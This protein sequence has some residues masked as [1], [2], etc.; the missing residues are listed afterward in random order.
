V[1]GSS[2]AGLAIG[3]VEV[4]SEVVPT[5]TV[6]AERKRI[7]ERI[8]ALEAEMRGLDRGILD[9]NFQ[10]ELLSALARSAIEPR[11]G[12][13]QAIITAAELAQIL[14][15]AAGRLEGV[16]RKVAEAEAR[17]R[18]IGKEIEELRR[19]EQLLS[20]QQSYRSVVTVALEAERAGEAR[21]AVRYTVGEAGWSPLYD[22]RLDTGTKDRAPSLSL[23]SRAEV[24]Q[25][26]PESWDGVTLTL[27]TARVTG[28][29]QA[30]EL[31]AEALTPLPPVV[32]ATEL[33]DAA[34]QETVMAPVPQLEADQL[35]GKRFATGEYRAREQEAEVQSAGFQALYAIAGRQTVGNAGEAK[36]VRIA[37]RT[38]TAG[39]EAV[40]VPRL[41]AN[42]YL[43]AKF[44]LEGEAP[45]LPG[46]VMLFRD[47]VFLG[48][49]SLPLLA[50]G[51]EHAMG[52][53]ADDRVKVKRAEVVR[54]SGE[55]GIIAT[56]NVEE[57]SF[58]TTV[59]NL[60][61]R[62]IA[63][64]LIDR[65]PFS[66]HEDVTVEELAAMTAPDERDVDKKRGVV[67]WTFTLAPGAE[68]VVNFG[69]RVSW[70]K[71][72]TLPPIN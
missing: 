45:L 25:R 14:D 43:T 23:V 54:K 48:Q 27:S 50:P 26:T 49:G 63:V 33:Q 62:D 71:E 53:G 58:S 38:L 67:A 42:A 46:R 51:E 5:G 8:E 24:L 57:R 56:A 18:Q 59:H 11:R 30:P 32:A 64:R 22:A 15:L 31:V 41:D 39:L 10:K 37:T 12:E 47:G 13:A 20:P 1:E 36:G 21:F 28:S 55:V 52:F 70:P 17:Q 40:A 68:E 65:M 9:L 44:T 72:M 35:A 3:S 60:H 29:T 69:Y 2:E 66:T 61:D 16:A 6:E 4:R 19:Q 7:E 34:R